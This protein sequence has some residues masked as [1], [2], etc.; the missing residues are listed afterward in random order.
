MNSLQITRKNR[1]ITALDCFV[2]KKQLIRINLE[3]NKN[4]LTLNKGLLFLLNF[5]NTV[6]LNLVFIF[7][8]LINFEKKIFI[9]PVFLNKSYY[10][11]FGQNSSSNSVLFY[12]MNGF[13]SF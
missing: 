12:C 5:R 3:V 9:S 1:K 7:C 11:N 2:V 4:L 6:I 13:V 10:S 8:R